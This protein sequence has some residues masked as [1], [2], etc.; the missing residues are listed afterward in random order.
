LRIG[1]HLSYANVTATLALFVALG[2]GAYAVD[3]VGSNDI[4]NGSVRSIDVHRNTVR[5][6]DVKEQTLDASKFAPIKGSEPGDCDPTSA[7]FIDCA[8]VTVN[9]N[10]RSRVL[11]VATGGEVSDASGASAECEVRIDDAATP[12][13]VQPGELADNTSTAATNGFARTAVTPDPLTPGT[14]KVALA[15]NEFSPDVLIAHPT[16]AAIA[17]AAP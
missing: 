2:G 6:K 1:R 5:G 4:R 3:K 16:I 11:A 10:K 17:I 14:H 12:L 7:I 9:L 13:S 8:E 15:C